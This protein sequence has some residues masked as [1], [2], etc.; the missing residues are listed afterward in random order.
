MGS[1]I[2]VVLKFWGITLILDKILQLGQEHHK[3]HFNLVKAMNECE[4]GIKSIKSLNEA[5]FL[6]SLW[7]LLTNPTY[8]WASILMGKYGRRWRWYTLIAK[9]SVPRLWRELVKMKMQLNWKVI[10]HNRERTRGKCLIET[11]R[12]WWIHNAKCI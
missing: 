1:K 3:I 6:K 7:T 12:A 5:F 2:T 10:Q 11:N 8:L 4:V 9:A